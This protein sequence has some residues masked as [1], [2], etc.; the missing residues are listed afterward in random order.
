MEA[1]VPFVA[2]LSVIVARRPGGEAVVYPV[3]YT[4]QRD[5][6]CHAV[7]VPSGMTPEVE[8]EARRVALGAV[9]AVGGVGLLAVEL[10]TLGD[11]RVLVNEIAPRPHNTGHLTIEACATSQF[12]NHARAVLDLPLGRPDLRTPAACMINVLGTSNG[13]LS[14]TTLPDALAVPGVA[15]HLYGKAESRP[16]RKLGHVTALGADPTRP[17]PAPKRPHAGSCCE[18]IRGRRNAGRFRGEAGGRPPHP[19]RA[20]ES[21][22]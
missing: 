12:E 19:P 9:E 6:R 5:H 14:S 15:V 10:F 2:E 21:G 16:R 3:L 4:E 17:A 1:F 18:V 11:G 8:A 7:V 20:P 13:P 22:A